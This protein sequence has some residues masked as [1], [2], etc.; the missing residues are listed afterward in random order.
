[1]F[2][3]SNWN[4]PQ[5][6]I[7]RAI[8][9]GFQ[10][11]SETQVFAPE[12]NTVNKIRGPLII[13]GAAGAGSLSL[14]APL[15]LPGELN[16]REKHGNVLAF[17]PNS[18]GGAIETMVVDK[19][20]LL[21]ALADVEV[22][23]LAKLK[24]KT[25]ELTGGPGTD[26][27]LDPTRPRDL[28][29]RFWLITELLD[30]GNGTVQLKLQ[31]PT[32]VDPGQPN[33]TAPTTA[34]EFAVT[35]LSVNFFV[36]ERT[37]VDYTT[38]FDQDSVANDT[39]TLTSSDGNVLGFTPSGGDTEQ[40]LV[41]TTDLLFLGL[42]NNDFSLLAGK[43]I[44][45]TIGPGKGRKWIVDAV[46]DTSE[47]TVKRLTLTKVAGT[48]S[49]APTNRSE[50]R[51]DGFDR[52]G[53]ILGLGMGPNVVIGAGVQPG[54]ITYGDMEVL[55]VN[56]GNGND[57]IDVDYTTHASGHTT[58]RG[59][60]FYT[61]TMLNLG[62]GND[63][64]NAKIEAGKDGDIAIRGQAGND[65]INAT[66]S[67]AP[68]VAFGEEGNDTI[69]GGSGQDSL[70]GDFGRVD[71]VDAEGEIITRLGHS[72]PLNPVNPPVISAGADTIT[73]PTANFTTEYGGLVG[74]MMQVIM[75]DGSV[76]H[77]RIIANT[78]TTITVDRPW[79]VPPVT[80]QLELDEN[81]AYRISALPEDQGDG[82]FRGPRIAWSVNREIGGDDVINAGDG[83]DLAV[84]GAGNDAIDAGSG[85]D[86][87][88][89]DAIR[90]DYT[91][92]TGN[93]G[94][95]KVVKVTE[96]GGATGNDT[97]NAGADN[98]LVIA[99]LGNDT[100]NGQ[101]GADVLVGDR[102]DVIYKA[103]GV[104]V[105]SIETTDRANGGDDRMYGNEGDDV[106]VGGTGGDALDGGTDKDL[107][108][109]DNVRLV[110][111][112]GSLDAIKGRFRQVAGATMYNA[113]TGAANV[114][115]AA[116]HLVP[117]AFRPAWA[118][119]TITLDQTLANFGND[120]MAG[121]AGDDQMF[122]QRG[123]DTAQGDGSIDLVVSA[124][125][126]SVEAATDGD[127]YIEGNAG[128]DVLLGNLG[129]DDLIGGSSNLFSYT[130]AALRADGADVIFGGAGTDLDRNNL[131]D[132]GNTAHARDADFIVGDNGN[133]FR[134]V[135]AA[136]NYRTF[137]YDNYGGPI[138][139]IPRSVQQLD[140]TFGGNAATDIGGAD[141]VHGESG[142]DSV[143]GQTGD[144]VLFGEGQDD[145]IIGG[146]GH[147]R[148][149][150]GSG[151]DGVLGDDGLIFTSRNGTTEPLH[152]VTVAN[153]ETNLVLPG[154]STG[155]WGYIS[156][157]LN[158]AVKLFAWTAGGNDVMYGGLGDD[159]MH[160]GQGNDAISGAE[161]LDAFYT[162]TPVI[163]ITPIDYDPVTRKLAGWDAN[164]PRA[165]IAN[166]LLNF[167]ASVG[168]VKVED[169]KDRIF[170][171]LGHDWLVGG[172]GNDRLFGGTGDDI[173]NGDDNLDSPAGNDVADA[174]E[175]ADA[176]FVYGGDG[177]DVLIGNTGADRLFDW[178]GEFNSF[179]VPFSQFGN[180]TVNR[181]ILPGVPEWL[182]AMAKESGADQSRTEPDGE[183]GL[184]RQGDPQWKNNTG[185]PRDPQPGTTNGKTDSTGGPED[186]RDTALP[187]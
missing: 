66:G 121:G 107:L 3:D 163:D 148:I 104:T 89:G 82:T 157:R 65:V 111:N 141:L 139:L 39:G 69:T 103:D 100:V 115:A 143:H 16:V 41:E 30:L 18:G 135:D 8:D 67:T 97:I 180:P 12:L 142:D 81:S 133:V 42:A 80:G 173:M 101:L 162:T 130:T 154:P 147:D 54:G 77:R 129:Q 55:Q 105:D 20:D 158:K 75:P 94:P 51:V 47:S 24:G 125:Q 40:M 4:V 59:G 73:D 29:D 151:E 26:V 179:F 60:A 168:G 149:Y 146:V 134:L 15:M 31:N 119:W 90:V 144:D 70:F 96:T 14:P 128:N 95:T 32:M 186:D 2:N 124:T 28:F 118:D 56:L 155:A 46:A 98:D 34:S 48:G 63:V 85:S 138:R 184:F 106:L 7:V 79:D 116:N 50:F 112:V 150:G 64:V 131:G 38:V 156:G 175:F 43:T 140:Y 35:A 182:L 170:G 176:D 72:I 84:G 61:L 92:I 108:F 117:A 1:V 120:Y 23:S 177:L 22:D 76:Q 71:F 132:T 13:E 21:A 160:G 110:N 102:A 36:D 153:L 136:G 123:N 53:R 27:I 83:N 178:S 45:I 172:T 87:V 122:G 159:F 74:L 169:G 185:K 68:I 164:N 91:P 5:E 127:D 88:G 58:K 93:D 174:A 126:A 113:T 52:H 152:G 86:V 114:T 167:E 187:L 9:D 161:A 166:H 25:I 57:Q 6:V 62:A 33:V 19:D 78:A 99:G 137:T 10:D 44:E 17:T 165:K 109:G 171:D 183:L 181:F 11:G 37:S 49:A 145:D